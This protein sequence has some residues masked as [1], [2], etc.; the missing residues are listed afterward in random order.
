MIPLGNM[1]PLQNPD[2]AMAMA[3]AG[4]ILA[5]TWGAGA[6]WVFITNP[7]AAIEFMQERLKGDTGD[8]GDRGD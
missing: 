4:M 6:W 2:A 7:G 3:T 8:T 1:N 5:S